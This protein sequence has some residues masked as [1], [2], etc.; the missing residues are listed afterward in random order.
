MTNQIFQFI[1]FDF[2]TLAAYISLLL[3]IGLIVLLVKVKPM[4]VSAKSASLGM[5]IFVLGLLIWTFI[6]AYNANV[7][8]NGDKLLVNIPLYGTELALSSLQLDKAQIID[9]SDSDA[10]KFKY[11]SNGMSLMSY[12]LGWFKLQESVNGNDKALLSVSD[13]SHVLVIPTKEGYILILSVEQ[14]KA[15]L[16]SL[17]AATV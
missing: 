12:K 1:P 7:M 9:L 13:S 8:I 2:P 14:P 15:L 10:P 17:T 16:E 3:G 4:P 6:K 11:R 5:V